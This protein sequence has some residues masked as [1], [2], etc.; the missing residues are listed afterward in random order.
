MISHRAQGC[1]QCF[2]S[3]KNTFRLFHASSIL[4]AFDHWN[5]A[6]DTVAV[7]VRFHK[8][9]QSLYTLKSLLLNS[10]GENE[11]ENTYGTKA[12]EKVGSFALYYIMN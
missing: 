10:H 5:S 1:N 3:I 2:L 11:W 8:A 12:T 6:K 9:L 4:C 7:I